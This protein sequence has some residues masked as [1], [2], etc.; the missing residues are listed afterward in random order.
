M[1]A[2][3]YC[4]TMC[5]MELDELDMKEHLIED[6]DL[7]MIQMGRE[8]EIIEDGFNGLRDAWGKGD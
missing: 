2:T 5:D 3:L 4:C 6:H 8:L 7:T 1:E